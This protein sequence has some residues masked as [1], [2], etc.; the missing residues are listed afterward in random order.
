MPRAHVVHVDHDVL[1]KALLKC[2]DS[3][4]VIGE[5]IT[6]VLLG[7]LSVQDTAS[8][9]EYGVIHVGST[10]ATAPPPSPDAIA[11]PATPQPGYDVEP[12]TGV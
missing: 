3:E 4:I 5:M 2:G 8:L 7:R 6:D 1:L 12:G 11:P 9:A 10:E